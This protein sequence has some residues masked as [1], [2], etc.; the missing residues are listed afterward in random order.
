MILA[1]DLSI[2]QFVAVSAHL[3]VLVWAAGLLI[4]I[5]A[6]FLVVRKL[7][8]HY[9]PRLPQPTELPGGLTIEQLDVLY[10]GGRISDEEFAAMR[11]TV[12]GLES[13]GESEKDSETPETDDIIKK[14]EK[15]NHEAST[16][17]SRPTAE[18]DMQ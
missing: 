16:G 12:L 10:K 11:R 5:L 1:D 18:K 2:F 13:T 7:R 3:E 17:P 6:A 8:R 4:V 14:V 15:S 9:D